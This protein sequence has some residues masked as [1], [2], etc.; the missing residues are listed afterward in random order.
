MRHAWTC[1]YGEL[2]P[3]AVRHPLS[4]AVPLL[5]K[6]VDMPTLPLAGDHHMPRVQDGAFGAS[7]RFAVSPGRER[8]GTSNCR[9]GRPA[10]R[11]R[12]SI[13]AASK[14]GRTASRRHSCPGRSA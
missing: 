12:R 10:I 5:P 3:V 1:K 8:D 7:E 4:G 9:A 11:C 6:L 14:I 2:D 13:A